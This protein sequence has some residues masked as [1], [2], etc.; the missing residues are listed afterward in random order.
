LLVRGGGSY[1]DLMPFNDEALAR[2]IAA[3]VVPV[4]T[5]I[6]HEPDNSIADMVSSRRASTPTA[7]AECVSPDIALLRVDVETLGERMQRSQLA[8]LSRRL[9]RIEEFGTRPILLDPRQHLTRREFA[10]EVSQMRLD[11]TVSGRLKRQQDL[12]E[13]LGTRLTFSGGKLLAAREGALGLWAAKLNSLSPVAVLARGYALA[14]RE[15]GR[16]VS[17]INTVPLNARLDVLLKDGTLVCTVEERLQKE[18]EDG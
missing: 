16:I 9:A 14:T 4:V 17:S 2:A 13:G 6:G 5:G 3:S 8:A 1:E 12:L 7:A 18:V 10:L 15:D 11:A